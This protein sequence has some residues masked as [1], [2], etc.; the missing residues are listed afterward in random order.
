MTIKNW[1]AILLTCLGLAAT[2][3]AQQ[4]APVED[5]SSVE[6]ALLQSQQR[7]GAA[8][9]ELQQA[10]H[11]AKLAEQEYLNADDAYRAAQKRAD[12]F[13]HQAKAAKEAL[14]A[15]KAKEIAVRKSYEK[16]LDAVDRL[17]RKP[18]K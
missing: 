3:Q 7:A 9:R 15:A 8:Y 13:R 18:R 16:A 14:D 2:A 4:S 17:R 12:D 1:P 6:S 11:E 5:I 10:Q